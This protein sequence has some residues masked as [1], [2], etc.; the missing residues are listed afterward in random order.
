MSENVEQTIG[1]TI[2]DTPQ[3]RA[4][5]LK[6]FAQRKKN[7]GEQLTP[8]EK[9]YLHDFLV[10]NPTDIP[11]TKQPKKGPHLAIIILLTIF[12][13]PLG[14]YFITKYHKKLWS[15]SLAKI[16]LFIWSAIWL[17]IVIA[18]VANP[19]KGTPI[20]ILTPEPAVTQNV[21]QPANSSDNTPSI[22]NPD[23]SPDTTNT[24]PT[25]APTNT[26]TPS[27]PTVDCHQQ[28]KSNMR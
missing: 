7:A 5:K 6:A 13:A 1:I 9:A 4:D 3:Q 19:P 22:N 25:A 12:I 11:Q 2:S 8:D 18:A 14:L 15:K 26:T 24:T 23:P 21:A 28:H 16:L 10:R 20:K 17:I 27:A